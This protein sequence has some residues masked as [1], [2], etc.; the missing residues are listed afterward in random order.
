[1]N[2]NRPII[3]ASKSPR[4]QEI[5]RQAGFAFNVTSNDVNETYPSDIPPERVAAF[6]SEKKANAYQEDLGNGILI[7]ADT[8]VKVDKTLLQ[9]PRNKREAEQMLNTLS[10][11]THEVITGVT[12]KDKSQLITFSDSTQ[13]TF[14]RLDSSEIDYYIT[15][16]APFDKAGAYGIQEWIGHIG[17]SHI[18]GSYFNVMGLPT[19]LVYETLIELATS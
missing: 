12:I 16:Y 2:F 4:R 5:L 3:L 6:L 11:R 9:K 14:D 13:V 10:D 18:E 15:K 17:I 1:M 19:H 8:V 7:T